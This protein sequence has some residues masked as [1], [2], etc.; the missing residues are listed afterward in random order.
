MNGWKVRHL[1]FITRW[2]FF[3][4]L[5][6]RCSSYPGIPFVSLRGFLLLTQEASWDVECRNNYG[7][8]WVGLLLFEALFNGA[9][10]ET[11]F[12][13]QIIF[14]RISAPSV[15]LRS[16]AL[17]PSPAASSSVSGFLI[18]AVWC[19]WTEMDF[20]LGHWGPSLALMSHPRYFITSWANKSL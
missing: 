5:L 18:S 20:A 12:N 1:T 8:P 13:K 3:W 19:M 9:L 10:T 7:S 15:F 11:I 6:R 16:T 14:S 17:Q 4:Y 2:S